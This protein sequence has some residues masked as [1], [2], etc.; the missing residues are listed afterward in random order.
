MN[1]KTAYKK[2]LNQI[3]RL[4][5]V[6]VRHMDEK[7]IKQWSNTYPNKEIILS[8]ITKNQL[9]VAELN[10]QIIGMIVLSPEMPPEY[11][12]IKW[13]E[14][15]GK[16]NSVHRLA[17][18]PVLKTKNLATDLMHFVEKKAKEEG[19]SAIRLD[20]YSLNEI[21]NKFYSKIGYHYCGDINL[22]FMPGKYYCYEKK[23]C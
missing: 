13:S 19:Y 15:K 20:T 23:I 3:L 7:G 9:I 16:I 10:T 11:D 21:A 2:D 22:Q 14:T 18:H 12:S 5:S 1:I 4:L 6:I 8:D 17:V